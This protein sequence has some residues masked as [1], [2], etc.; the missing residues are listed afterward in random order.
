MIREEVGA[1]L[2]KEREALVQEVFEAAGH[3]PVGPW[4]RT[5]AGC[6]K[7]LGDRFGKVTKEELFAAAL[8][9]QLQCALTKSKC[10]PSDNG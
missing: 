1:Y 9:V 5:I 4:K 8:V 3:L 2:V 10:K 7:V 6:L